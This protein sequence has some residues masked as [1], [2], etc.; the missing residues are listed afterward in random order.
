M[1]LRHL[2]GNFRIRGPRWA[3]QTAVPGDPSSGS[4]RWPPAAAG[5]RRGAPAR[6]PACRPAATG[7][8]GRRP[9]RWRPPWLM[10]STLTGAS[11]RFSITVRW[12][13]RL[14]C[15]NTMPTLRRKAWAWR[16]NSAAERLDGKE[17]SL[18]AMRSTPA[19]G[20]SSRFIIRSSELLPAPLGPSNTKVSPGAVRKL[21]LLQYRHLVPGFFDAD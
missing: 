3:R 16:L 19:S 17:N 13:H 6:H 1:Y 15:W 10:P 9:S 14:Y 12:G 4:W 20:V 7:P 21:D 2:F 8:A 5:H 18:S 11:I